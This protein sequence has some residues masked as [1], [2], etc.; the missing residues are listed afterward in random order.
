MSKVGRFVTDPRAGA[1]SRITL[2]NGEKLI[3]THDKGDILG[4]VI[5]SV[6]TG[7][8]QTGGVSPAK[9]GL[10]TGKAVLFLVAAVALGFVSLRRS[11]AGAADSRPEAL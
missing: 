5:L 10:L 9:F 8:V 6:M 4:L 2:D 7:V 1:Y 11:C 3:V